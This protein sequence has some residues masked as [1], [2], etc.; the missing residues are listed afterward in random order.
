MKIN[1]F[2]IPFAAAALLFSACDSISPDDRYIEVEAVKPK[3]AVLIE[4]FTGQNCPNC[5]EGHTFIAQLR[6]QYGS[7]FIPVSIHASNL[8]IPAGSNPMLTGLGTT[9]GETYYK[10]AG[11]PV[12]P[13]GVVDRR[14]G[15]LGRG[16]WAN[17]VRQ[18]LEREAPAAIEISAEVAADASKSLSVNVNIKP[19]ADIDGHLQVWLVES[20]IVAFQINGSNYDFNYVHDHVFRASV[21]GVEGEAFRASKNVF[22]DKSYTYTLDDSWKAEN[23]AVV[24]FIYDSTGVL[25]AAEAEVIL[26]E[27]SA[28]D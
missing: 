20:G 17:N 8:S 16:E 24:A 4:E 12:L 3:R 21:N 1:K 26:Q 11:S 6:E 9:D 7:S 19:T 2:I 14:S 27:T 25:Q 13:S 28:D 10:N 18:E 15:A 22:T 23:M 5:P